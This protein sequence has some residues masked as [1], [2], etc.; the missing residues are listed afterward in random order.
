MK[1]TEQTFLAT[2]TSKLFPQGS[3]IRLTQLF[4]QVHE[5]FCQSNQARKM[6]STKLG[7]DRNGR[8]KTL[9]DGLWHEKTLGYQWACLCCR[10]Q[11]TNINWA[12]GATCNPNTGKP[13]QANLCELQASLVH[14]ASYKL[15][16]VTYGDPKLFKQ[17]SNQLYFRHS[18]REQSEVKWEI[19]VI[20]HSLLW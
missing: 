19:F 13:R 7:E 16:R 1:I 2:S 5:G 11:S 17:K 14:V 4:S 12:W 8:S 6:K 18:G 10:M 20:F 15:S 3:R 9:R